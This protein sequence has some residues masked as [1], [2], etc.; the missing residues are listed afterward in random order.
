MHIC[1][2]QLAFLIRIKVIV[3]ICLEY[4]TICRIND[5]HHRELVHKGIF[6]CSIVVYVAYCAKDLTLHYL[7]LCCNLQAKLS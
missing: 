2:V 6:K 1:S 7:N 3:L 4:L 5:D